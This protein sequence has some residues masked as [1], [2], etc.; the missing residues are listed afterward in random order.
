M[1]A[2]GRLDPFIR[3]MLWAVGCLYIELLQGF[4][5]IT[6][7]GHVHSSMEVVPL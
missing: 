2:V 3:G 4:G 6:G 1:L 5:D 7:H